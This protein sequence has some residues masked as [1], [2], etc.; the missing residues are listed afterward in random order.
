VLAAKP[1][2]ALK[3]RG[4]NLAFD[5]T[6]L[7]GVIY[8]LNQTI[9]EGRVDKISQPEADEVLVNIRSGGK[10]YKLLLTANSSAPR[11][12][13][14]AQSK[15]APL[16]APMFCMVLRKHISGGRVVSIRQPDFERIVEIGIDALDEMG[17]RSI[18]TLVVEIMGKHSNIILLDATGRVL[19]AI[20]HVPLS[21]SSVRPVMPGSQYSRPPGKANPLEA[22]AG[23]W[24]HFS[25]AITAPSEKSQPSGIQQAIYQRYSGISPILA[26]EIC[27]RANMPPGQH[28]NMPEAF[29]Q[30]HKAFAEVMDSVKAGDFSFNIY[31]DEAGRAVDIAALPL[32]V[33][34]GLTAVAYES[35]SAML[36]DFYIKRDLGYRIAQKTADLRKLITIHL[37]RCQK[38]SFMFERTL[39]E[40]KNRDSLRIKGELLTA[41]LHM[42][43]K[44]AASF[45]AENYYDGTQLE[46][47]LDSTLTPAE[48]SQKYFKKYNKQ[49]RT[50]DALQTQIATN[51]DDKMYLT[52]LLVAMETITDEADIAEIRAELA[53][54]GFAK[55]KHRSGK[56]KKQE[57]KSKPLKFTSSDGYDIYVGKNNTQNDHLTL[58]FANTTDIWLHTKDIAGSHVIIKLDGK[59]EP[60]EATIMEAANLAAYH[61]RAKDSSNVPVDYVARRN[62]KKPSGAKPGFVIYEG[63]R[64]VYVTPVEPG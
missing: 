21:V 13:L 37:E 50:H 14:T 17:D 60:P 19:D 46:I 61:S 32:G 8:E 20:K 44:G 38:K 42:V 54:Q 24:Q 29:F 53:E 45:T 7:A 6:T 56:N 3:L 25:E 5:G 27:A 26:A 12:G 39:E 2:A 15:V 10:N 34:S 55:A 57:Q 51:N 36:E 64:T 9:L 11:L 16:K 63:H 49:K 52:S 47:P 18:K 48:N 59:G 1:L 43:E 28:V 30:L 31:Q 62:V 58:K 23:T 4:D 33:Y 35:A 22:A 41:Y 40:I